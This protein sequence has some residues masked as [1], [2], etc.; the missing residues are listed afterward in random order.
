MDEHEV[1]LREYFL[2]LWKEKWVV[3]V[4][5]VAAVA[6]ALIVVYRLPAQYQVETSLL[7]LPPLAQ[8]VAG[9]TVGTVYSPDT[10]RRLAT[11]G[12]L[13][14][15]VSARAYPDGDGPS[16]SELRERM[17]VEV[18]QTAA[19]DFPGRFPLYVRAVF[20]GTSREGLVRLATAWA[21]AFVERN[22]DLLL[23]RTAQS[24]SYLSDTFSDVEDEL[25]TLEDALRLQRQAHSE[26]LLAVEIAELEQRY[27]AYMADLSSAWR[28]VELTRAEL[29]AIQQALAREPERLVVQRG[30]SAE[31]VWQFLGT[32]PQARDVTAFSDLV[33][34]EEVL[35]SVHMGLRDRLA[36]GET[37]LAK[38][39]EAVA[40]LETAVAETRAALET[41]RAELV[42]AQF[43]RERLER[44]VSLL[45]EM[46]ARV[47]T[48]LQ[49]ARL[50]RAEAAEP[51][52]VVELPV[53]PTRPTGPNK[54][55]NVA[56]AGVLGLFVGVLLAFVSN[57]VKSREEAPEVAEGGAG[58]EPA[59]RAHPHDPTDDS[60]GKK[61]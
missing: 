46:Y 61:E 45:R 42:A 24:Y 15:A 10:Y 57:A 4:T 51:I 23:A 34:E 1:D 27:A 54:Q 31:A 29:A 2:I 60:G 47:G 55:M 58:S 6:A 43:E 41:R 18:A 21:E 33:V 9:T 36:T 38:C 16:S 28:D 14:E 49:E 48:K 19:G 35:N 3:I 30:P 25:R 44:E 12:D 32:R 52:R 7:I 53:L 22:A 59:D 37:E 13:L 56:V 8:D 11:A 20:R 40:Y 17:T 50:A 26:E 39:R 5:F